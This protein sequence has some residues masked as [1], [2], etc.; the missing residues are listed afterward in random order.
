MDNTPIR[1][2]KPTIV[3]VYQLL[4]NAWGAVKTKTIAILSMVQMMAF[5]MRIQ[6]PLTQMALMIPRRRTRLKITATVNLMSVMIS[7]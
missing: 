5:Y 1:M 6:T 3:Q 2:K 7:Q 4:E